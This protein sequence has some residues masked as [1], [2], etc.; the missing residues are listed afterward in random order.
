MPQH[1]SRLVLLPLRMVV[2]VLHEEVLVHAVDSE[3]DRRGSEARERPLEPVPPRELPGI[4]PRLTITSSAL[5][6]VP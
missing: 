2:L 6:Q 3:R 4:P 1:A 5:V